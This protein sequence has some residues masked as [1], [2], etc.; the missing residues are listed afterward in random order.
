MNTVSNQSIPKNV[1]TDEYILFEDINTLNWKLSG[2]DII[3]INI[4]TCGIF[5]IK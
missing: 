1:N 4:S 5:I 3:C 2:N